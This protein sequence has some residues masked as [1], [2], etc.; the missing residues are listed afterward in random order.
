[1]ALYTYAFV[2]QS[3]DPLSLPVGIQQQPQFLSA[4]QLL[5]V[6]EPELDIERLQAN[7]E[8]LIQAVIAHDRVIQSVFEQTVVLPLRFGTCFTSADRLLEHLE[9]RS[10][11]YEKFLFDFA[12]KAEYTLKV[13]P[14]DPPVEPE[15]TQAK[16]KEYL[17]QKKRQYQAQTSFQQRQQ[18][19]FDQL[20]QLIEEQYSVES[21]NS[22]D[23]DIR[24]INLLCDRHDEVLLRNRYQTWSEICT[25]WELSLSEALPPYHFVALGD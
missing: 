3:E 15:V 5:A 17:L 24:R 4:G 8:Q 16:G 19:E 23:S 13:S 9:Q 20:L 12:G 7:D 2:R 6:V 22:L 1:M 11:A 25:C 14:V 18:D 10:P 21:G